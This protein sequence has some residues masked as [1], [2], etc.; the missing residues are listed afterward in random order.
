MKRKSLEDA[1]CPVA[2]TLDVIGDWW[3]LLIVRDAFDGVTR[4][5]EFQKGLGMAKNILATRLRALVS[6]GVLEI[7][8]AADGSAYLEYVLTEKGRALFPVI[9]GLRQWGEDHL[10]AEGEAH[11]TLV[12]SDSGRPVPRLT[13]IGS[14]GQTL[15]PLNTRV[16]K[17]GERFEPSFNSPQFAEKTSP[18]EIAAQIDAACNVLT[19]QL[20]ETLLG[21]HLYGS[22]VDG[23]LKPNSDID[24][25]VAVSKPLMSTTRAALMKALL[26]V[27]APPGADGIYR[28]LEVT[29]LVQTDIKPWR[30]PPRRELQFGEWL[31]E[32]LQADIVSPATLD[33]D[34]A[35]LLTKARQHHRHLFGASFELL[36]DSVPRNDFITALTDT[37]SQWNE[38]E[39]WHGDEC[40]IVLALARIWFSAATGRIAPKEVAAEWLLERLPSEHRPILSTAQRVYLGQ[41]IDDLPQHQQ[42]LAAF[43]GY[44]KTTIA[45]LLTTTASQ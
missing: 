30:Y 11:S 16:V 14:A 19:E 37:L 31:R 41:A 15:T 10:F 7:V 39:D 45:S 1:P 17:V 5:S 18:C 23:G 21:I 25:L 29:V 40:N 9:V 12:E 32:E 22:A 8:P 36:Y 26:T 38:P 34:V 44:A 24:L 20:G 35:I 4:F 43:I 3:S 33:P 42:P 6:H 2:R 13:P 27:S 28:P